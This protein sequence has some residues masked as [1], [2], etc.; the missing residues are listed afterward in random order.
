M[1]LASERLVIP[2]TAKDKAR[3]EKNGHGGQAIDG[4]IRSAGRAQL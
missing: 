4:R 3:V 2:T 1:S